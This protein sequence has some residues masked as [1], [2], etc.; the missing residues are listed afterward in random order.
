MILSVSDDAN[1][2]QDVNK[3][4]LFDKPGSNIFEYVVK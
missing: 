1:V 4:F 2:L 3:V